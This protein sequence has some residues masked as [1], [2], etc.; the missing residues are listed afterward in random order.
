MACS[1]S[2]T[3]LAGFDRWRGRS[4]AGPFPSAGIEAIPCESDTGALSVGPAVPG[5]IG[6]RTRL[7][8][9]AGTPAD[10]VARVNG[11]MDKVLKTRRC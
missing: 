4:T 7:A 5:H 6:H 2:L 11:E 1:L 3:P 10:V 9:P 8:A